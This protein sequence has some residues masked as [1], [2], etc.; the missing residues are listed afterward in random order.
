VTVD[1]PRA[2]KL[3][4]VPSLGWV[5]ANPATGQAPA[6]RAVIKA[7]SRTIRE[8]LA[9]RSTGA[10]AGDGCRIAI[11]ESLHLIFGCV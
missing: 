6:I 2:A 5:A 10:K 7:S 11:N 4:A 3:R 1:P 9:T 8:V